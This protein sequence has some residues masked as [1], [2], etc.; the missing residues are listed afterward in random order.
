MP[1]LVWNN[2][3]AGWLCLVLLSLSLGIYIFTD[4]SGIMIPG[5]ALQSLDV[6]FPS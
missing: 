2:F 4:N 1:S 5:G 6:R 3:S